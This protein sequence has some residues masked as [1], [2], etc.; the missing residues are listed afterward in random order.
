M[1]C[2]EKMKASIDYKLLNKS[3]L[4]TFIWGMIAHGYCFTNNIAA[5][6]ALNNIYI[7]QKWSKAS[8]GRFF[9]PIYLTMT[10]GRIL[11]PWLVG[12]IGVFWTALAV[13]FILRLF[14][15]KKE[16]AIA[17]VSAVCI[18]NPT[19]YALAATYL[20]DFDA[21]LFA[22]FIAVVSV[23]IWKKAV[24][25]KNSR[26]CWILLL[27]AGAIL[28]VCLGIYQSYIS[29]TILLIM[30]LSV[31]NLLEDRELGI[32]VKQ[33]FQG[34]AMLGFSAV[35]YLLE[36][37]LFSK[38]IG[39]SIMGNQT[40]NGLGNMSSVL[41]DNIFVKILGAYKDFFTTYLELPSVFPARVFLLVH[42]ILGMVAI[43]IICYGLKKITWGK[44][45]CILILLAL[46]P[47]GANVS[48]ILSGEMVHDIMKYAFWMSYLFVMILG[49]W[50]CKKAEMS[51]KIKDIVFTFIAVSMA[52]VIFGNI[53]TSNAIYV[54]KD[55][56][57]Q[58][59]LSY[60]TRVADRMEEQEG[61]I[62]G[63]TPVYF[64]GTNTIGES[65]RGFEEYLNITGMKNTSPLTFYDTYDKYFEYVLCL[66]LNLSEDSEIPKDERVIEMSVFP[67]A[68]S[69]QMIDDVLVVKLDNI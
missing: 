59:T 66:P 43:G 46:I 1:N 30:M 47:L 2:L 19:V 27:V 51:I 28:S 54:K 52:V 11:L 25:E 36:V 35:V 10:R 12:I 5:H 20:H 42:G 56:E 64:V 22:L 24:E 49:L 38:I 67:K 32:V 50:F 7:A 8:L 16:V 60:M 57:Y 37:K 33:G 18:T 13:Y 3:F 15:I 14:E 34:I 69:V 65:R 68:G 55:L 53:Q 21:D 44:K 29:V 41:Q 45:I 4:Y 39:T 48:Y 9:Y 6:D 17:G 26:K 63:E 62:P 40:Y 61:Y 31:K 58:S 23:A